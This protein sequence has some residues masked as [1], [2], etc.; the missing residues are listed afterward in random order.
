V[1]ALAQRRYARRDL[2]DFELA[3]W[4]PSKL[5]RALGD[6]R[7]GELML[8]YNELR[9]EIVEA[10]RCGLEQGN[11]LD[12]KPDGF[13]LFGR[14]KNDL[15]KGQRFVWCGENPQVGFVLKREPGAPDVVMT[16]LSRVGVR[17]R[18]A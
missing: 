16:T 15:P 9:Q 3:G 2:W 13:V 12:H 10:V 11:I 4:N 1:A 7:A 17:R 5:A 18:T 14:K 8:L 6:K